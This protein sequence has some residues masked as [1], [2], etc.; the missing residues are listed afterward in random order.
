MIVCSATAVYLHAW[1]FCV[2]VHAKKE[3][4]Q[5]V[6]R[7]ICAEKIF[8]CRFEIIAIANCWKWKNYSSSDEQ[9]EEEE[10]EQ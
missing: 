1:S 4:Q 2:I 9:E 10:E 8:A 5:Q 6:S 3:K 7:K